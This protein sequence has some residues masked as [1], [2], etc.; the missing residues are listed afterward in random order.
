LIY[1][2]LSDNVTGDYYTSSET[3]NKSEDNNTFPTTTKAGSPKYEVC[4]ATEDEA[5][6][7]RLKYLP[8]PEVLAEF[9]RD[10]SH[11]MDK[12]LRNIYYGNISMMKGKLPP[13]GTHT[14]V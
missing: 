5:D 6:W 7:Q 8:L 14:K 2:L 12:G 1:D 11:S 4:L 3:W 10:L 13:E 9:Q